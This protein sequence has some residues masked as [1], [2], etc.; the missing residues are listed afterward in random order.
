[1]EVGDHRQTPAPLPTR[2]KP[3]THF[4]RSWVVPRSGLDG[5]RKS[6]PHRNS[7]PGPSSPWRVATPPT[8]YRPNRHS[9]KWIILISSLHRLSLPSFLYSLCH[10]FLSFP[11]SFILPSLLECG[12]DQFVESKLCQI[13]VPEIRIWHLMQLASCLLAEATG[14]VHTD[15]TN[16]SDVLVR[17]DEVSYRYH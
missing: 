11:F 15:D 17:I 6:R 3:G 4:I 1:M 2:K 14:C 10:S 7:I 8:L 12:H 13:C 9:L 16:N 5:Y